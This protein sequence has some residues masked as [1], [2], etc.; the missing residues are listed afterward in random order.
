LQA[1][2]DGA[3][4]LPDGQHTLY[5]TPPASQEQAY[6]KHQNE[7]TGALKDRDTYHDWADELADAIAKHTGYDI[8]EHSS[9]NNP[10]RMALNALECHQRANQEQPAPAVQAVPDEG[11]ERQGDQK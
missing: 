8:G 11:N 6:E 10:W 3:D 9:D 1:W 4:N 5:T 7:L 2:L